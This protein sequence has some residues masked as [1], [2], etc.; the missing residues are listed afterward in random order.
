ML[1]VPLVLIYLFARLL[2]WC[3]AYCNRAIE[4]SQIGL[5]CNGNKEVGLYLEL[6]GI[7]QN[8]A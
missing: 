7:R 4:C 6:H 1:V 8:L 5:R 2:F 3:S